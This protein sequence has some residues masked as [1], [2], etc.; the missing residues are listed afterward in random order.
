MKKINVGIIG[1]GT[2]GAG[3]VKALKSKSR[4]LRD[5]SGVD[6]NIAWICDKDLKARRPVTVNKKLLTTSIGKVI[7]DPKVDIVVELVGGVEPAKSIVM[8]ALRAGK[9][10]VTANK[11][12]LSDSG[13]EIFALADE[14]GLSVGFEASVG[15]GIPI[16]RAMKEGFIA[17]RF[18]LVYGII[19]G[20]SN[21]ILSKMA[22]EK[23]S[24]NEAL[25]IA[26]DK[27]YAERDPRLDIS[28]G[29]SAHKLSVL[30]SLGFG[31]T[32]KGSDIFTEG[33]TDIDRDDI[34]YALDMGYAVKPLAIAKRSGD[35]L[36]LRVHPTLIEKTHLLANVN[37]VYNAIFVKGDLVG[38]NLFY[39]QGA[40]A[41]PTSSAVISDII[42]IAGNSK[43]SCCGGRNTSQK[44]VPI[45][46]DVARIK[47]MDEV[48]TRYYIKFLALDKPGVL[49]KISGI[50]AKHN[51][52]IASVTQK[53]RRAVGAVPIV[54]MTHDSLEKDM[55]KALSEIRALNV[56]GKKL[57]RI[58]VEN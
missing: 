53:E 58:R 4:Y 44:H 9:S 14:L 50:L 20:T 56:I 6:V 29:D 10:V 47:K 24:F 1:F 55:S 5:K 31:I 21:F 11:A 48:R 43:I 7:Y 26:Q 19:N 38:E 42:S 13:P 33:I 37:G 30:A 22:E 18:S 54:M 41:L 57:V 23:V 46:K 12:L 39:G 32:A 36:E 16:I 52:S 40:G 8:E 3:V 34:E 35:E 25:E 27:G 15:G 45:R 51:I 2:I 49:A 28:G 17:N